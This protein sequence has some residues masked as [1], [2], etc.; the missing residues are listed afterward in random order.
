[1]KLSWL[2]ESLVKGSLELEEGHYIIKEEVYMRGR[3][4]ENI[5]TLQAIGMAPGNG[6]ALGKEYIVVADVVL[7]AVESS[8]EA[9]KAYAARSRDGPSVL[10]QTVKEPPP[11][12][13]TTLVNDFWRIQ[14][15]PCTHMSDLVELTN[16]ISQ[17]RFSK[18][19]L[20]TQY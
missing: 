16:T 14:V 12:L 11:V 9:E 7:V 18:R 4:A 13:E 19:R 8:V 15:R 20:Q 3:M 10:D 2:I 5:E 6:G 17:Y 1:M